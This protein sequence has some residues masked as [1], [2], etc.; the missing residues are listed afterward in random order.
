MNTVLEAI[1]ATLDTSVI[2]TL[3]SQKGRAL[4]FPQGIVAQ[5]EQSTSAKIQATAG[6]ALSNS[7][8]LIF[9]AVQNILPT[10]SARDIVAYA[11]V[12]GLPQ[13]RKAWRQHIIAKNPS[14]HAGHASLP[15]VC[16]GL[17]HGIHLALTLFLNTGDSV[18]SHAHYWE[19]YLHI[20]ETY[21]TATLETCAFFDAEGNINIQALRGSLRS[22]AEKQK[23]CLLLLNFPNNP[24]GSTL[25]KA[26][27]PAL[28]E[29]V[30]QEAKRGTAVLVLCD[31]AY[32]GMCF[33]ESHC[34]QS[35]FSYFA[36][37]HKNVLAVKID[38]ATKEMLAWGLRVGFLSFGNPELRTELE[39]ALEQKVVSAI[40]AT[41]TSASRLS[42]TLLM[43]ILEDNHTEEEQKRTY[44]YLKTK[45]RKVKDTI[46]VLTQ[47]YPN[48]PLRALNF[49]S[50]YFMCFDCGDISAK[51]LRLSL[52]EKEKIALIQIH[53]ML[54]F[55]FAAVDEEEIL[56]VL[57]KIYQYAEGLQN[58]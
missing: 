24:S 54:R 21:L 32:F 30:E 50:G 47:Q 49:S 43:K 40:R 7:E 31:D 57:Q 33:E 9:S 12:A 4:F 41:V 11:P 20:I 38:G 27:L 55:T 14:L 6:M 56:E 42:Q 26:D 28:L 3:L 16:S 17:T 23:K 5:T 39:S 22:M 58:T 2:G 18:L 35:L 13:L 34:S 29:V 53:N 8:P 48:S 25:K 15:I 19:N 45:Y 1:N 52:L 37:L 46:A 44:T 51:D 10:L 36:S